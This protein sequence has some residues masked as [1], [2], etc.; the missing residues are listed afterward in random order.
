M[1][2]KWLPHERL[3]IMI[4]MQVLN[5]D[6]AQHSFAALDSSSV[7]RSQSWDW[8]S[9]D[10][11]GVSASTGRRWGARVK[12]GC[13]I[14]VWGHSWA[15]VRQERAAAYMDVLAG[16]WRP[17]ARTRSQRPTQLHRRRGDH[18]LERWTRLTNRSIFGARIATLAENC[19][20]TA[21]PAAF[22]SHRNSRT[23]ARNT[24][25]C[26]VQ[27]GSRRMRAENGGRHRGDR[28]GGAGTRVAR[29]RSERRQRYIRRRWLDGNAPLN[30]EVRQMSLRGGSAGTA[31]DAALA[32]SSDSTESGNT[33]ALGHTAS[34]SS[35][36]SSCICRTDCV[37]R[38]TWS[39]RVS[40]RDGRVLLRIHLF[41]DCREHIRP[42]LDV[43]DEF[44]LLLNSRTQTNAIKSGLPLK[45]KDQNK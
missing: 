12:W 10:R 25:C 32:A 40:S 21:T 28:W 20:P 29:D 23:S 26:G 45:A 6:G 18:R 16:R 33:G 9:R 36:S 4:Q 24:C 5:L 39:G 44:A 35:V 42:I 2:G 13:S 30:R 38:S 41:S 7:A 19:V 3:T 37:G 14:L 17:D 15:R 22:V 11:F 27:W 43:F 31:H 8:K 1:S 34:S